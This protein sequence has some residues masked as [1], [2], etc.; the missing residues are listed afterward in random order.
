MWKNTNRW[1]HPA[2]QHV[3]CRQWCGPGSRHGAAWVVLGGRSARLEWSSR[4]RRVRR[5]AL[6]DRLGVSRGARL[7]ALR[8]RRAPRQYPPSCSCCCGCRRR[9]P[10]LR[11]RKL[12]KVRHHQG[13]ALALKYAPGGFMAVLEGRGKFSIGHLTV[14]IKTL[15]RVFDTGG[16]GP[17]RWYFFIIYQQPHAG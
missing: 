15:R 17:F 6:G 5:R 8:R 4:H 7:G 2:R 14:D 16:A 13:L 10:I 3:F 9:A 1:V 11:E 12:C